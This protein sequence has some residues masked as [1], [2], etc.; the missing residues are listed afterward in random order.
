MQKQQN[1]G[2]SNA[3]TNTILLFARMHI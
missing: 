3:I 2:I 1:N